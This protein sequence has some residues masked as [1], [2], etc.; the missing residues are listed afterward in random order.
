M[1]FDEVL[2]KTALPQEKKKGNT[3]IM[4]PVLSE[5]AS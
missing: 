1:I 5:N 3:N 4:T 2:E